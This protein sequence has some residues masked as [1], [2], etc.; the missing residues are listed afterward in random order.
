MNAINVEFAPKFN[1]D[2][3]DDL[4]L[5]LYPDTESADIIVINL[6]GQIDTYSSSYFQNK[7]ET[8]INYGYTRIVFNMAETKF[9]SAM[10]VSSFVNLLKTISGRG[11]HI[12]LVSVRKNV[13]EVFKLSRFVS[14][15]TIKEDIHSAVLSFDERE[16]Y[17]DE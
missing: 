5:S 15:F 14:L 13:L 2:I 12:A 4:K 7:I 10:G 3:R 9:V 11:G 17:K 16:E 8:V 1:E 6:I